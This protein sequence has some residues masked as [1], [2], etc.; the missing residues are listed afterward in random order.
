MEEFSRHLDLGCGVNPRNPY[1]RD[2]LYAVDILPAPE[3][4]ADTIKRADLATENIPFDGN[5]F[6]SVSA[7]DFL[8]HVPRAIWSS[9]RG[10]L[11]FPFVQ[12]MSEVWRVLKPD[13]L[14][15][16]VTPA[17]PRPEAFAD[18]THLNI[19]TVRTHRYFV[20]PHCGARLYGFTGRF[21]TRRVKW[22]RPKYEFEP[23]QLN[24][25]QMLRK[26]G[27]LLRNRNSH[28]LWELQAIK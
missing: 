12:L 16:A 25:R 10:E 15:Y 2:L 8:E 21:R 13:G 26:A 5:F 24:A 19:I 18:P 27:D 4:K 7:Y 14:F 3:D 1:R 9:G 23:V 11:I 6:D 17:Y 22:I 20:E 28:L